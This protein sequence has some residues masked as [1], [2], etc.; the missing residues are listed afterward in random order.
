M[1]SATL[2]SHPWHLTLPSLIIQLSSF[3]TFIMISYPLAFRPVVAWMR[4]IP[5]ITYIEILSMVGSIIWVG[6]AD[7]IKYKTGG[8][9]TN[10]KMLVQCHLTCI[11]SNENPTIWFFSY[12]VSFCLL[13]IL[14]FSLWSWLMLNL[15][16]IWYFLLFHTSFTWSLLS[17]MDLRC[18]WVL[19]VSS[20]D[21]VRK[22]SINILA[23]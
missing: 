10:F 2:P 22:H 3:I 9:F 1:F 11:Y 13:F 14:I 12:N 4:N 6:D 17:Y 19:M 15:F 7:L 20:R 8:I 5:I 21:R 23:W 16:A 18:S